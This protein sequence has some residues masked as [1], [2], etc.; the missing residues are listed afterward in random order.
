MNDINNVQEELQNTSSNEQKENIKNMTEISIEKSLSETPLTAEQK[1]D[2]MGEGIQNMNNGFTQIIELFKQMIKTQIE[3]TNTTNKM[4]AEQTHTIKESIIEQLKTMKESITEVSET[5]KGFITKETEKWKENDTTEELEK[6]KNLIKSE[7]FSIVVEKVIRTKRVKANSYRLLEWAIWEDNED[8]LKLLLQH[9]EIDI[10]QQNKDGNTILMNEAIKWNKKAVY[11]LI[12]Q[13]NINLNIQDT[14]GNTAL[15]T[16]IEQWQIEIAVMLINQPDI[17]I[18]INIQNNKLKKTALI[19]AIC[20]KKIDKD[21]V[22]KLINHPDI[23]LNLQDHDWL[24]ALTQAIKRHNNTDIVKILINHPRIEVNIR[25]N[26]GYTPLIRAIQQ[27]QRETI[28]WL[29]EHPNIDVNLWD[30]S[31]DNALMRAI[32]KQQLDTIEKLVNHPNIDL[33]KKNRK[34]ET[35]LMIAEKKRYK[36]AVKIIKDNIKKKKNLFFNK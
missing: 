4:I 5:M 22:K 33:N 25:D 32:W 26:F 7:D 36:E 6:F 9:P 31:G 11:T 16:A 23:N 13:P 14:R 18:D 19:L 1:M 28:T 27:C 21:L 29:I 10:N 34:W 35:A 24:I 3:T 15:M 17:N 20:S 30:S 8:L 12:N 2:K